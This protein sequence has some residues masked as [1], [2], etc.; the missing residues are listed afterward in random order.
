[1]K[2][3]QLLLFLLSLFCTSTVIHAQDIITMR[4][5]DEI[6]AKISEIGVSDVK[7]KKFDNQTGP[8]YTSLKSE[9]FMIKYENG[10]KDVFTNTNIAAPPAENTNN[11][12]NSN[13]NANNGNN[14]S[15]IKKQVEEGVNNFRAQE[16]YDKNMRLYKH[17]LVKGIVLTSI[18]VPM[19]CAG[20]PLLYYGATYIQLDDEAYTGQGIAFLAVGS[21]FTVIGT[22]F[23]IVGPVNIGTSFKY[24]RLAR[25]A[26]ASMTF[27]PVLGGPSLNDPSRAMN[28]NM[29]GKI[30]INF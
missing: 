13:S 17:R 10:S 6:K 16:S 2:R 14:N 30:K 3:N 23:S 22:V 12:Y 8:T 18:G 20:P 24:K 25:E 9:I 5:G 28:Y 26:K 15:N 1:M 29:G 19:L 4:N 27:E 11:N 21:V 7:Y